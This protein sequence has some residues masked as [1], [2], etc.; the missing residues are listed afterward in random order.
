MAERVK[1][2]FE[3]VGEKE[4][5]KLLNERLSDMKKLSF[6]LK[7]ADLLPKVTPVADNCCNGSCD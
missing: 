5:E 1:V 2:V 7:A 3:G 6:S 4:L